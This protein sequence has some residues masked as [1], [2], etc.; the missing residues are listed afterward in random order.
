M[1]GKLLMFMTGL[2]LGMLGMLTAFHS[3]HM[4]VA[5]LLLFAGV[6]CMHQG[7]PSPSANARLQEYE[8]RH[9]EWLR[10]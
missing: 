9:Q 8:R 2:I 3:D 5:V 6:M 4:T 10:K 7:L 1:I